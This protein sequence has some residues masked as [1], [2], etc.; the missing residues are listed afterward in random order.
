MAKYAKRADG[1][2]CTTITLPLDGEKKKK[3]IYGKTIRE[4]DDKIAELRAQANKGIVVDDRGVTLQ[5]WAEQWLSSKKN[6]V[7]FNTYSGYEN[8][9]NVHII[10]RIGE[11]RLKELK[12]HHLQNIIDSLTHEGKSAT[13]KKVKV[14]LGQLIN[15][16]VE[17]EYIFKDISHSL[18]ISKSPDSKK[19][20]LTQEEINNIKSAEL[21]LMQRVFVDVL[22]YTGIRR[23]EALALTRNDI[24]LLNGKININKTIVFGKNQSSIKTCTKT[25]AGMR[26][27]PIPDFIKDEIKTHL[28]NTEEFLFCKQNGEMMTRTGFRR[29]WEQIQKNICKSIGQPLSSDVTPHIFRH[30]YATRLFHNGVDI[31]TA[32][33]LLGHS[34]IQVT[35]GIYTHLEKENI[36]K[37]SEI[38]NNIY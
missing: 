22:L 26:T 15:E 18:T 32:Q 8:C 5:E 36:E 10:P 14:T 30:T 9:V 12:K 31:K 11:L 1:R 28:D 23:G 16:A 20:A 19:R 2:Y 25:S 13:A 34:S 35:L 6:M 21:P 4:I 33:Y 27:L 7:S 17:N 3:T 38:V 29:F 37:F 24:D